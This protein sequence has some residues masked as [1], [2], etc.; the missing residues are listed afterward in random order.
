MSPMLSVVIP[1]YNRHDLLMSCVAALLAQNM[2][3][4]EII[5]VDNASPLRIAQR[6]F[7]VY[8]SRVRAIR[9]DRNYFYC[10]AVNRGAAQANAPFI[11]VINDDCCVADNW[12][13]N[14]MES[15]AGNPDAG[16]VAS[17]VMRASQPGVIDS[18]GD[19]LDITGRAANIHWNT[20]ISE[21]RLDVSPVF[22]AA[23]SC[24]VYRRELFVAL[25]GFDE[26]FVAYL[27]DI[28]IGFRLQLIGRPA[29]FNPAC[30]AV[31]VGGGTSKSR[32]YAAYLMERNMV[33]NLVKNMPYELIQR[34][35]ARIAVAQ[36]VPAP[37]VDGHSLWGWF[38]GKPA[39]AVGLHK[40]IKK[41]RAIQQQR[42]V[43]PEYLE[44]LLLSRSVN[45]CH[46]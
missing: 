28:D 4:I 22:S 33:W 34:N 25:G 26:D 45:K 5:V 30:R 40:M 7:N 46:L 10:G 9:L 32:G 35:W 42:K 2:D 20:P 18:A 1:T 27:D 11:A 24:A 29:I 36:S 16:S 6:V 43:S 38:C 37:L 21:T 14:V 23:G 19:H 15:F 13:E 39:G 17:L 3:D 31:H 44:S 12:A 41:R 8:G